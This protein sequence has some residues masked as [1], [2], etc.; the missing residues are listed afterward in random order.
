MATFFFLKRSIKL[1]ENSQGHQRSVELIMNLKHKGR[2]AG[3]DRV[4]RGRE[5]W[6][7]AERDREQQ[8]KEEGKEGGERCN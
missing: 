8:V 4:K 6:R 1:G 5:G 2:E 7:V 3:R